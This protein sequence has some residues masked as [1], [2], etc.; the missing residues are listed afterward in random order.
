M[1]FG[2][3]HQS[4]IIYDMA[5]NKLPIAG[6]GPRILLGYSDHGHC[7]GN[8]AGLLGGLAYPIQASTKASRASLPVNRLGFGDCFTH[9][10]GWGI[11]LM[12]FRMLLPGSR[13]AAGHICSFKLK[14][15]RPAPQ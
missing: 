2:M 14:T 4:H 3:V 10:E 8:F 11:A 1:M 13:D 15:A 12:W 9:S 5:L 6:S 7:I